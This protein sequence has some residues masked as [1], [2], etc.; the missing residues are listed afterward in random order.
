M[1]EMKKT[2]ESKIMLKKSL[3]KNSFLQYYKRTYNIAK[4]YLPKKKKI[5]KEK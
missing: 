1:D 2:L 3:V 4:M 5:L